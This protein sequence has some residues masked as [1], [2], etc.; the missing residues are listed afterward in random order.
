MDEAHG[1]L[2]RVLAKKAELVTQGGLT[3]SITRRLSALLGG[4]TP[5]LVDIQAPVDQELS[6]R[7]PADILIFTETLV[8][9]ARVAN[10]ADAD[11]RH[12]VERA[13]NMDVTIFS[14]RALE[15]IEHPQ[16]D[17]VTGHHKHWTQSD[18]SAKLGE[19]SPVTLHYAGQE[20]I[21]VP[22][23]FMEGFEAFYG[24]LLDDL[25]R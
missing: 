5:V 22:S 13:A 19:R 18:G 16:G 2:V 8:L 15:R 9:H 3:V 24:S 11:S 20:P 14:R 4:Q 12:T 1:A 17:D 23:Q 7:Y 25:G 6:G 10:L 21:T